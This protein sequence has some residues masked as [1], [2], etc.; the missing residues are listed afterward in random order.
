MDKPATI[1]SVEPPE[2]GVSI[3]HMNNAARCGR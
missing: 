1:R 3:H 2:L